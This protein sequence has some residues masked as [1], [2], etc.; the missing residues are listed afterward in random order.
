MNSETVT[1][2]LLSIV[3]P[4]YNV[5]NY[6]SDCLESV[7]NHEIPE[8]LYEVICVNDAS[9]DNSREIVL[10]FQKRHTNLILIEH[11]VNR[12][13]G[14]ARNTGRSIAKGKYIWNVDSDDMINKNS[15]Q[16]ILKE[17]ELFDLDVL[18]FNFDRKVDQKQS[19]NND[20][21]FKHTETFKGIDFLNIYCIGNF[22]EISPI[23]TQVYKREFLDKQNIFSP[24]INMG[25]D[26]PFTLKSLLLA[27][28]IKSITQSC[29]VYRI[30]DLSLGG[31]IEILPVA[32]KLYEKCF[33]CARLVYDLYR[34]VPVKELAVRKE[35]RAVSNYIISIYTKYYIRLSKSEKSNFN[36]LC[37]INIF[38]DFKVIKL[39][40]FK[41]QI[42]FLKHVL[43]GF[44]N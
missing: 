36:T 42:F 38:Y 10:D 29:Y 30:N 4:F 15:I 40:S 24:P 31:K 41:N 17:C 13:L 32:E 43:C 18:I 23:W 20:Y 3:I 21:P 9:P 27:E 35:F 7:Y 11:D 19:T 12:K 2:P 6:I 5:E 22:S 44:N 25:E 1:L 39:L 28:R 8:N 37:R 16:I 26:V 14:R 34:M 33:I